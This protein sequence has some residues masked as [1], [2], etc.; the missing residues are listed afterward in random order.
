MSDDKKCQKCKKVFASV[1]NLNK[2]KRKKK[3]CDPRSVNKCRR[4]SKKLKS[5]RNKRQYMKRCAKETGNPFRGRNPRRSDNAPVQPPARQPVSR[6]P[7][8]IIHYTV[9]IAD[10][11]AS[12]TLFYTF[13]N[14][15]I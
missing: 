13:P 2:H 9:Y 11:P 6:P 10:P 14:T 3:K 7:R 12:D 5:I 8:P 4:E 15:D 1:G